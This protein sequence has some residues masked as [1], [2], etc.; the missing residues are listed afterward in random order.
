MSKETET[1]CYQ[2]TRHPLN[3][4]RLRAVL[5]GACLAAMAIGATA[6]QAS[7]APVWDLSMVHSS[8]NFK[9]GSIEEYRLYVRNSGDS[10]S[11]G[12][13]TLTVE[14][15]PG[16]TRFGVTDQ[17]VFNAFV[18]GYPQGWD[19]PG[20]EGDSTITCTRTSPVPPGAW[21]AGKLESAGT[22]I[23]TVNV[24]PGA[25]GNLTSTATVTGG[26]AKSFDATRQLT[27]VSEEEVEFGVAPGSWEADF[28]EADGNTP[29]R[30]AS[31]HPY[32]ATFEF[33]MNAIA[34]PLKSP[35]SPNL[36][37][38]VP[39]GTL[40]NVVV[41]FPP[42]FVGNPNAIGECTE[43]QL[44][45]G[46]CPLDS[47]VGSISFTMPGVGDFLPFARMHQAVYNMVHPK[48]VLNDLAFAV[49]KTATIHIRA[50][51]DPSDYHIRTTVPF[52]SEEGVIFD[53]RLTIWGVPGDPRHDFDRCLDPTGLGSTIAED[54]E[55]CSL[56]GQLKP[57]LT[58]PG[59]CN[60]DHR[61]TLH[62]VDSWQNPGES[63]PA[64]SSPSPAGQETGCDL[65]RFDPDVQIDPNSQAANT[66]T[67]LDVQIQVPQNNNPNALDTAH[68]KKTVLTFPKGMTVSP[69][70]ADGL[71]SC[72]LEQIGL[73]T[74]DPVACPN[75]SRIGSVDLT[76]PLLPKRL[77]GSMY[78]AKQSDN[79]FG[80]LLA[81]YLAVHDTEE[82]GAL[83]K[84]AGRIDLDQQTGQLVT[85]FDDLPQQP[86]D[87]LTLKFRG[88]PR[89]PLIN[90]PNC[91]SHTIGIA[92]SS[93]AK[94]NAPVDV[95]DTYQVTQG[96]NGTPCANNPA[97]RPFDPKISGGTINPQA[98]SFSPFLFRMTRTDADQEL[99]QVGVTV[100]PGL[101]AKLAGIP[102][103]PE[104]AIAGISAE[105]ATSLGELSAPHCPAASQIGTVSVGVGAGSGPNYFP[106]KI[107]LGGPYKGAPLSLAV[108][109]AGLAGP[110]DLGNVLVR[111]A[112]HVNPETAQVR[113]LS[114]PFPLI[115]HGVL[116]RV[117]DV[118]INL[119]R[120]DL[121]LN[122]TN[123]DPLAIDAHLTGTGGDIL[124]TADDT[125]ADRSE[126]FQVA[127][128]ANLP[129]KPKLS[130]ELKGGTK[131]GQFPAFRAVLKA[132]PGDA[133]IARSTVVLPRSEFIEQGHIRTVCTRVQFKDDACP[134]GSIYGYAKA[135]TP[136]FDEVLEGPVYLRSNGGERLLP[137][138]VVSLNGKIDVALAG[139]VDSVNGRFRNTF[140]VIPDAPVTKF[141]LNM[142][143]G[144]RGLLVNHLDLCDVTSRADVKF[145]GQNGKVAKSRPKMGTSCGG[146]ERRGR[147]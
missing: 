70:F 26:G 1:M 3:I 25:T 134:P 65:P 57:F 20:S 66:P 139:F 121:T 84:V 52:I 110:F 105:L 42:G 15:P 14:L 33:D 89:A 48:G 39:K 34:D 36:P 5:L 145:V 7:A 104:A 140:D 63:V 129:F 100:P 8:G 19:C 137:D 90:P 71:Q 81:M 56:N 64:Q 141:E 46:E 109:I 99:S 91:G 12:P 62:G 30:Q 29:V 123:C 37:F 10:P 80:S 132:R 108:V 117:R 136:L 143:G 92:V 74:N 55:R 44:T 146:G 61:I 142:K 83:L 96:P 94:P 86:F 76:S 97:D 50:S 73:G 112:L 111:T 59:Q 35:F 9:P 102:F 43:T 101:T 60:A 41:D 77:E 40:R 54:G 11:E 22:I 67:G 124:T 13:I 79:P 88:G 45:A 144:K 113:A 58:V 69:S 21:A 122:P 107:Y 18:G 17:N 68:I 114:D 115:F 78:L 47:Q 2:A 32:Q 133:N 103:C 130:F 53:Q 120:P 128:C 24:D 126:R 31:A 85:T 75:A 82:R 93:W 147:R 119:D 125:V 49:S 87:D 118:R 131:R 95:S 135:I 72:T 27:P 16:L 116:L 28:L 106:G 138:L 98:G 51:L 4:S 127:N 38:H 23:I 6:A